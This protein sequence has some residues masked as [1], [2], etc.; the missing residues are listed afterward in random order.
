MGGSAWRVGRV[1]A[2]L[3]IM[4]MTGN[5]VRNPITEAIIDFQVEL[6]DE[7]MAADLDRC[8][9]SAYPSKHVLAETV[10]QFDIGPTASPTS[11]STTSRA[12]G[13]LFKSGDEKQLYQVRLGGFTVNRLSP[14]EGWE[15]FSGEAC[16]LWAIYRRVAWPRKV[17]RLA[18]RYVNR[19]DIPQGAEMKD[20]LR[21]SPD[22]SP[23]IHQ[24]L[25]NFFMQMTIPQADIRST[26]ILNEA[27]GPLGQDGAASVILDID[28]FRVADLGEDEDWLWEFLERLRE[29]KNQIFEA[30]ITDRMREAFR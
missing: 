30:C 29:R 13:F 26:L 8:E 3:P 23:D 22:V 12:V 25:T 15:S 11:S 28:L 24:G 19:L 7:V 9:D 10:G 1:C 6:P 14:Y 27:A 18:V 17:T 21:T 16:R 2:I 20:Y 4:T 5:Y